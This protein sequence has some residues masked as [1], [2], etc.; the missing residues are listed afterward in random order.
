MKMFTVREAAKT[1]SLH[2][3]TLKGWIR[4]GRL[5]AVKMGHSWRISEETLQRLIAN[6]FPLASEATRKTGRPKGGSLLPK[7]DAI[8]SAAQT[9]FEVEGA[10]DAEA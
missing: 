9:A 2:P 10:K 1:L 6:G 3:E 5:E 8:L 7:P 4:T